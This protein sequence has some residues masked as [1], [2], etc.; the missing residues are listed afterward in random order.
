MDSIT[1]CWLWPGSRAGVGYGQ[2]YSKLIRKKVYV[3]RFVYEHYRGE[4]PEGFDVDHLC[5]VRHCANPDHLRAVTHMENV[6][7]PHSQST[8]KVN[9]EKTHCPQGHP[10]IPGNLVSGKRHRDCKTCAREN[11]RR[12]WADPRYRD[13]REKQLLWMKQYQE[14]RR[15][16]RR[17]MESL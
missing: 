14:R 8:A 16:A 3:H 10:L 13:A 6:M 1:G 7:A 4:I 2:T 17:A 11:K 9:A 5:C 12:R 15:D